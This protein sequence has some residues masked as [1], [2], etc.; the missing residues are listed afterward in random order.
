MMKAERNSVASNGSNQITLR[1]WSETRVGLFFASVRLIAL[2]LVLASWVVGCKQAPSDVDYIERLAQAVTVYYSTT[3]AEEAEAAML[4]L[5]KF[6]D[7]CQR[8]GTKRV[9]FDASRGA[10]YG[11]LRAVQIHLGKLDVAETNFHRSY[12]NWER[13]YKRRGG[14]YN[15]QDLRHQ[16]EAIDAYFGQ[17]NWRTNTSSAGGN[18]R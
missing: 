8:Q 16:V 17:P 1:D 12:E 3:N 2:A 9:D 13:H 7:D 15:D 18:Q 11:R 4:E 10:L 6:V 5:E 14:V